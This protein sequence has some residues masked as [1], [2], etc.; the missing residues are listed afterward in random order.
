MHI[1]NTTIILSTEKQL[2][3]ILL[4]PLGNLNNDQ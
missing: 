4:L 2:I 1:L 3:Y